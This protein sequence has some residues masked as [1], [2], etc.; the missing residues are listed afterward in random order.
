MQTEEEPTILL[1]IGCGSRG[2]SITGDDMRGI[3][4]GEGRGVGLECPDTATAE[5]GLVFTRLVVGSG[6]VE[7]TLGMTL[8][9]MGCDTNDVEASS[10]ERT[11]DG[12]GVML[13]ELA[14]GGQT[15]SWAILTQGKW[16][17]APCR[18]S[19][20]VFGCSEVGSLVECLPVLGTGYPRTR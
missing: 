8:G 1:C 4:C 11:G 10:E 15:S 13:P 6:E 5:L 3:A 20:W 18:W 9:N 14:S 17:Q 2:E 16:M 12:R 19:F 7:G